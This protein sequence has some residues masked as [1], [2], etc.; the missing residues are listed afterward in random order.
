MGGARREELFIYFLEFLELLRRCRQP[1]TKPSLASQ[2]AR[3]FG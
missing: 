3:A 2:V 1:G